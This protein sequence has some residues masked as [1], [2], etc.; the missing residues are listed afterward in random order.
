MLQYYYEDFILNF[1]ED[2][3]YWQK[4]IICSDC[5]RLHAFWCLAAGHR[6]GHLMLGDPSEYQVLR[7][8]GGRNIPAA[9]VGCTWPL[10]C[11]WQGGQWPLEDVFGYRI[12]FSLVPRGQRE[13]TLVSYLLL[14][15][16]VRFGKALEEEEN[17]ETGRQS[18]E[19]M[20]TSEQ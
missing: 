12:S 13:N 3:H 10:A 9:C 18:G 15:D 4:T 14:S 7:Q 19:D 11:G 5:K 8:L 1:T 6:C 16:L 2:K 17:L 20:T